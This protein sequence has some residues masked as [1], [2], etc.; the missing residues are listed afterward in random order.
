MKNR[1]WLILLV[2]LLAASL[3]L[4]G[5][6]KQTEEVKEQEKTDLQ[7]AESPEETEEGTDA[8]EEPPSAEEL[9]EKADLN[10]LEIETDRGS[11]HFPAVWGDKISADTQELEDASVVSFY[12]ELDGGRYRLFT[13][14]LNDEELEAAGTVTKNEIS[15]YV[16]L[17]IFEED[18]P[19][20]EQD[21][22]FAMQEDINYL[23]AHL[24]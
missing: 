8:P 22:Y 18:V 1:R 5:C 14:T 10:D 19:E 15:S 24:A 2:L 20:A 6:G 7:T 4:A 23:I 13:V 12:A 9:L 21:N 3:A 11:L 17:D 16:H